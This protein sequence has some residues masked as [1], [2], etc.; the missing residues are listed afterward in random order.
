M[1]LYLGI[2]SGQCSRRK[3]AGLH[4]F[5]IRVKEVIICITEGK[6]V[7]DRG[8]LIPSVKVPPQLVVGERLDE[9]SLRFDRA[10]C[11]S[12]SQSARPC[13]MY[14]ATGYGRRTHDEEVPF[15]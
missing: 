3:I 9:V 11:Q 2:V 12:N 7:G 13:L 5:M 14:D 8:D 1:R 10:T 4:T 15:R 6:L